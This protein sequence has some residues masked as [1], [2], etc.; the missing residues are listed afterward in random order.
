[1]DDKK[2]LTIAEQYI[3]SKRMRFF[4][5]YPSNLHLFL[6]MFFSYGV[7][8]KNGV[9]VDDDSPVKDEEIQL[10]ESGWQYLRHNCNFLPTSWPSSTKDSI[11]SRIPDDAEKSWLDEIGHFIYTIEKIDDENF[12]NYIITYQNQ[13]GYSPEYRQRYINDAVKGL[14]MVKNF[15]KNNKV[16][17]RISFLEKERSRPKGYVEPIEVKV[18]VTVRHAHGTNKNLAVVLEEGLTFGDGAKGA[19]VRL[20][21][22]LKGTVFWQSGYLVGVSK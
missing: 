20:D 2:P 18:G 17:E 13:Q 14:D 8:W 1:M 9:L 7:D 16:D 6:N 4:S 12:K 3:K 10:T 15:I 19:G 5:L 22:P 11:L 21:K